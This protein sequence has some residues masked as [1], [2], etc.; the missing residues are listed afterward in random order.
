MTLIK[1]ISGSRGTIGGVAGSN[2]TALDAVLMTAAYAQRI[3]NQ[4]GRGKLVIGRDARLSGAMLSGL[5]TG[6]LQAMGFDVVDLG[7]STTP[8]VAMWVKKEEAKGGLVLTA[9][10]N[11]KEWNALKFLNHLGEF[12]PAEEGEAMLLLADHPE[13]IVYASVD[14][15]GRLTHY[16]DGHFDYH[17]QA[18]LSHPLVAVETIRARR[19]RIA[20]D[21]VNSTGALFVPRL[22][23][24]LGCSLSL[25]HAEAHGNFAHNPEPLPEHLGDLCRLVLAEKA[26]LGIAVDPDVDRLALVSEDGTLFGEEYTLVAAADYVLSQRKGNTVSNLSSTRALSDITRAAGGMYMASAVGEVNV[27]KAMKDTGA[28]IGGEGNGGVILPD[29]HYGRDAFIGIALVLSLLASRELSAT[30]L[31]RTYPGYHMVKDRLDLPHGTDLQARL[32]QLASCYPDGKITTLDGLKIDWEESWV[33]LRPSNTEPILRIYAE[34]TSLE[35]AKER[36]AHMK[37]LFASLP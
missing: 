22:L 23:A 11:P 20:L 16:P 24:A 8:T 4:R 17:L 29:L 3:R 2:L 19:F 30:S 13:Q 27:V 5:V 10:H 36:V 26:D 6:T 31:R 18:I 14:E 32:S 7:L 35:A 33:H 1:S 12:I 25:V 9:S 28:V 37:N 21:P 15:L 34:A